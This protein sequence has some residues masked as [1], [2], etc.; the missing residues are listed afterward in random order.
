M[1]I[2]SLRKSRI[3]NVFII[4]VI[5]GAVVFYN[6]DTLNAPIEENAISF[7]IGVDI[8]KTLKENANYRITYNIYKFSQDKVYSYNRIAEASTIGENR[9]DRQLK[10]D[11]SYTADIE[12]MLIISE[13]MGAY[14][15]DSLV[16][17]FL[18]NP[19]LNDKGLI[20]VCKGKAE[21]IIK[22]KV[23]A[24][25]SSAE[26]IEGIV[27][28]SIY[29]NFYSENYTFLDLFTQLTSEGEN[30]VLP[31]VEIRNNKI[32]I[33]GVALF[34]REKL[35]QIIDIY[36]S[37]IMNV[38]REDKTRGVFSLKRGE[39]KYVDYNSRVKKKVKCYKDQ[40]KYN[41]IIDLN[42]TGNIT[43]NTLYEELNKKSIKNFEEDMAK[44]IE[45]KCNAFIKKMQ[46]QYKVDCL[47]LGSVAAAKFGRDSGVDWNEVVSKSSIKVRAKVKV[48]NVGRG[49]Y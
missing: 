48:D 29:Y 38:L 44:E 35:V 39:Q 26:Y 36:E 9:Q 41:F 45:E 37:K 7:G 42:V 23:E 1:S 31:Y 47:E 21:D 30:I 46:K 6:Y 20:V 14:G 33:S 4:L 22:F 43:S 11:R 40:D 17:I 10:I 32:E 28:E 8:E 19:R 34:K 2:R 24:L 25:P 12:R 5:I 15:I 3:K 18:N 16:N 13:D 27:K 49:Q